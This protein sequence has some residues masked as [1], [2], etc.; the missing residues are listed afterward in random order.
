M[1]APLYC[2][3]V[4]SSIT[5]YSVHTISTSHAGRPSSSPWRLSRCVRTW[6]ALHIIALREP[7]HLL[8]ACVCAPN[9]LRMLC[10]TLSL[11]LPARAVGSQGGGRIFATCS[12]LCALSCDDDDDKRPLFQNVRQVGASASDQGRLWHRSTCLPKRKTTKK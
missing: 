4:Q 8:R 6:A 9:T 1:G 2:V 3:S 12:S 11:H 10:G 5:F 7:H